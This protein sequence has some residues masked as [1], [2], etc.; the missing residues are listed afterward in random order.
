MSCAFV[1]DLSN[2]GNADRGTRG[3]AWF[4]HG[5]CASAPALA[6]IGRGALDGSNDQSVP[7]TA[8]GSVAAVH[9]AA[10]ESSRWALRILPETS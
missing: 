8:I 6:S 5:T 2:L 3:I 1:P 4:T 10:G 9:A 7:E